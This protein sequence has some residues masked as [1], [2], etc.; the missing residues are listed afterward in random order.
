MF[1]VEEKWIKNEISKDTYD[2]WYSTYS[3]TIQSCRDAIERLSKVETQAFKILYKNL[4]LLGDLKSI[5]NHAN[6]I[7]KRELVKL[8]FDSN[9]YYQ[10]G[11]YRTP[12]MIDIMSRNHLMMKEKGLLVYN[13][14]RDDFSIIPP[15]GVA[16]NRTR[17]QTSN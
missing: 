5:Y 4:D 11:V 3:N 8:V 12:T 14:K 9:L 10:Q 7:Q 16:E 2:R 13:K 17:V 6:I 1:S 15:S